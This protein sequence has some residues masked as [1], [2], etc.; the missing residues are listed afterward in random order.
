MFS[1]SLIN[2][3]FL[4]SNIKSSNSRKSSYLSRKIVAIHTTVENRGP[5]S[6]AT[7]MSSLYEVLGISMGASCIEIK[8]AYRKLARTCHPDVVAMNQKESSSNQFMMIHLAYSTLS[9][10]DKRA[11]YDREIYEHRRPATVTSMSGRYRTYSHAGRKWETD[12]CW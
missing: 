6:C 9:D 4:S 2:P 7:K 11:R 12:Q 10:P 1:V 5:C 3:L 8:S